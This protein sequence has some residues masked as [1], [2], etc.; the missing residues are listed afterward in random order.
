[1]YHRLNTKNIGELILR[2]IFIDFI[3]AYSKS[4]GIC[5]CA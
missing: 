4:D 3:K 1:M 2:V 5:D